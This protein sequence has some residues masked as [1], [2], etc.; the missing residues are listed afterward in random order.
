MGPAVD[1][2]GF[3]QGGVNSSDYYKLYNNSQLDTAERSGLGADIG[4]GVVAAVAQADDVILVSND[5]NNLNL[6]V[7]LTE[8]YCHQYRVKLEPSKTKLLAYSSTKEAD[9]LV[10]LAKN[11]NPITIN[12]T[13]IEFV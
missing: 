3:E 2:T 5:I 9:L 7:T 12:N 6:L 1:T 11:T 8:R 4:S 13:K 10:K